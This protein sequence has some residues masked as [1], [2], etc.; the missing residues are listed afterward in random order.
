MI[1]NLDAV[2]I[3]Y[4]A[5]N[6]LENRVG[7]NVLRGM[8]P[9]G[10]NRLLLLFSHCGIAQLEERGSHNPEA[11]SSILV[12]ATKR[13]P[14]SRDCKSLARLARILQPLDYGNRFVAGTRIELVA[15]GL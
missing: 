10:R 2:G 4:F 5:P 13:L 1:I 12:P 14:K 7:G 6:G 3:G 9:S 8:R 15:S 11:T